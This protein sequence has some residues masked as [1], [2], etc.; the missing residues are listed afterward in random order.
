MEDG[1]GVGLL[2][3]DVGFAPPFRMFWSFSL[4]LKAAIRYPRTYFQKGLD[5]EVR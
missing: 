3:M 2:G 1:G 4:A 5:A